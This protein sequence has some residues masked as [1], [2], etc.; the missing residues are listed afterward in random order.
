MFF[1]CQ[2]LMVV[3]QE[4]RVRRTSPPHAMRTP[5]ATKLAQPSLVTATPGFPAT[6]IQRVQVIIFCFQKFFKTMTMSCFQ[7]TG[8]SDEQA[9]TMVTLNYILYEFVKIEEA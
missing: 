5:H 8:V 6:V 9:V 3:I 2:Q 7:D 1:T 4:V